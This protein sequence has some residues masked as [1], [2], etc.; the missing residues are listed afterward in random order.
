MPA[1][2]GRRKS[3][4]PAQLLPTFSMVLVRFSGEVLMESLIADPRDAVFW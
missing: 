4:P 3:R 2:S 1:S